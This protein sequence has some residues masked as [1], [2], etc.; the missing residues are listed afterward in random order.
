MKEE[1]V[2]VEHIS[3]EQGSYLKKLENKKIAKINSTVFIS[4]FGISEVF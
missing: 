1:G 4:K 3:G 2:T